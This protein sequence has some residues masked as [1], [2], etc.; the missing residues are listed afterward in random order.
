MPAFAPATRPPPPAGNLVTNASWQSFW[1]NEVRAA[2]R[3]MHHL[4]PRLVARSSA[5][6][7]RRRHGAPGAHGCWPGVPP[8]PLPP[9]T[10][11]RRPMPLQGFTVYLERKILGRLYGEQVRT[12]AGRHAAAAPRPR[13][14]LVHA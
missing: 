10:A 13:A 11:P 4:P 1:L 5:A 9:E 2:P 8:S 12:G 3:G 14:R 7:A 6:P